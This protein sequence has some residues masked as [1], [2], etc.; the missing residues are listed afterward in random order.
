MEKRV[1]DLNSPLPLYYQLHEHLRAQIEEGALP[2]GCPLPT[3]AELS[4]QFN[5]SRATVREAL[6][7]LAERGLIEKRQ[8]VGSF[9]ANYKIDEILPGLTSFSTEMRSRGFAVRSRVL[10]LDRIVPPNRVLNA[11]K[12][13]AGSQA[14]RVSRLRFV[15]ENPVVISTSYLL[16]EIS[17]DEDFSQ[18]IY[19]MLETRYGY[20]VVAGRTSIEAG[21]ADEYEAGLLDMESGQA[22]L[23]ITWLGLTGQG[24]P[25]EYS[26]ATYR[27]DRYRYIV[28]LHR[29]G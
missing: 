23:R 5:V 19:E 14:V 22:L 9:V 3:E 11:L 7:G 10:N 26:E 29:P 24:R 25:V 16:P 12:L 21:L 8:G 6:R 13:S 20:R 4:E 28:Q 2:A 17:L 18:S 15:D 27:G 1:L